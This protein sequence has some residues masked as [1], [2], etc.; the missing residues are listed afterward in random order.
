VCRCN[1]AASVRGTGWVAVMD[2]CTGSYPDGKRACSRPQ[3]H[4]GVCG[5]LVTRFTRFAPRNVSQYLG[6]AGHEVGGLM[7]SPDVLDAHAT[8]L[9]NNKPDEF[10]VIGE[11]EREDGKRFLQFGISRTWIESVSD[12]KENERGELVYFCPECSGQS[13]KH[14]RNCVEAK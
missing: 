4:E 12:F 9:A 1:Q 8:A 13:G 7:L 2:F 14:S 5:S 10:M 6:M 11:T 3:G